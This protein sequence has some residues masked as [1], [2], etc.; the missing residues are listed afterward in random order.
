MGFFP[1]QCNFINMN[2][3]F[4]W[5]AVSASPNTAPGTDLN[6]RAGIDTQNSEDLGLDWL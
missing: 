3:Q 6:S 1:P 2:P 5:T 4:G